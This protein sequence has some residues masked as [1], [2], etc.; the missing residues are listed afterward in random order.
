MLIGVFESWVEHGVSNC[1]IVC[2]L[3]QTGGIQKSS[4]SAVVRGWEQRSWI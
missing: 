4:A 3:L 1:K 2:F